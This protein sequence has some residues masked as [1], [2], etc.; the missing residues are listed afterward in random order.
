MTTTRI[1][2]AI[3]L[4]LDTLHLYDDEEEHKPKEPQSIL[5]ASA[6]SSKEICD[7]VRADLEVQSIMQRKGN[8]EFRATEK[9]I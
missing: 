3:D 6:F 9:K 1:F 4:L 5:F 7:I 8:E 2:T